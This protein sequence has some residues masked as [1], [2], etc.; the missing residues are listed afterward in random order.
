MRRCNGSAGWASASSRSTRRGGSSRRPWREVQTASA[1]CTTY[2]LEPAP[3]TRTTRAAEC[4]DRARDDLRPADGIA[5]RAQLDAPPEPPGAAP[6]ALDPRGRQ[7]PRKTRVTIGRRL[8]N[9]LPRRW[10]ASESLNADRW[11]DLRRGDLGLRRREHARSADNLGPG[12]R[13]GR[14]SQLPGPDLPSADP[15]SDEDGGYLQGIHEEPTRA[16]RRRSNGSPLSLQVFNWTGQ[17]HTPTNDFF[18]TDTLGDRYVP[19][20]NPT[21]N[22]YSYVAGLDP[23]MGQPA[24]SRQQRV[25]LVHPGRAADLQ[26]PLRQSRRPAV[27]L[28]IVDPSNSSNQ[29]TIE[30]DSRQARATDGRERSAPAAGLSRRRR[31]RREVA[32][33]VGVEVVGESRVAEAP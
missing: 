5:G 3:A 16:R 2:T 15:W 24:G 32:A 33:A 23:R 1:R 7:A 29:S 27:V 14:Q 21:P 19:L 9:R 13:P 17:A 4:R 12:L 20:T 28:H 6:A 11:G 30:L 10:L 26:D 25:R 8:T 31:R 18:I 22:P